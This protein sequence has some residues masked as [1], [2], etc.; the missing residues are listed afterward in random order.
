MRLG[1]E[2]FV[3]VHCCLVLCRALFSP[4]TSKTTLQPKEPG[5]EREA[6]SWFR[7]IYPRTQQPDWPAARPLDVIQV[8]NTRQSCSM[9]H[10][11]AIA[12]DAEQLHNTHDLPGKSWYHPRISGGGLPTMLACNAGTRG[13]HVCARRV[14]A[15]SHE[16]EHPHSRGHPQLCFHPHLPP[17]KLTDLCPMHAA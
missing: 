16:P 3:W 4:G 8:I 5:T 17:G 9:P 6:V 12:R 2:E 1:S 13:D 7:H 15:H 11:S 10:K 14:V